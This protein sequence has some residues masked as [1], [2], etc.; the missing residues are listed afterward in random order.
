[1]I[2]ASLTGMSASQSSSQG[3]AF[4]QKSRKKYFKG[5]RHVQSTE[6]MFE[7]KLQPEPKS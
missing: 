6:N 7:D 5:K 3:S 2:C 4:M 1:M